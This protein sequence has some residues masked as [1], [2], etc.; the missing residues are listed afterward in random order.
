MSLGLRGRPMACFLAVVLTL[1]LPCLAQSFNASLS[2]VIT[3]STGALVPG[4]ELTLTNSATGQ[5]SKFVTDDEGRYSFQNL[6]PGTYDL[7][8]TLAGFKEFRQTGIELPINAKARLNITLQV[9]GVEQ[10]VQVQ[11][12]AP[13]LNFEN[14]TREEGVSP[15]TLEK[16]PLLVSGTV[17]SAAGFAVLMPGVSTGGGNNAFDARINGGVQSGDEAQVD[18][19]SMQQGT[20][21]QSG[22]ISIFQ[23]FPFSPD[24]VSEVK[25]LTSNYEPQYGGTAGATI[26]AETKSGT[27]DFHASGFWFHRNTV[28]N[29]R[30]FGAAERPKNLQHN[31]GA[32]VGGPV[33][34]PFVWSDKIKTYFYFNHEQFRVRGGAT[35]PI[36]SIP[37]LKNRAGD[38]SDWVD[39][40]GNLIP[41][42]DPDTTRPNPS[43]NAAQE[44]GPNNLPFLRDQFMGCNGNQ[45]NV[46]C[47]TRFQN[48]LALAWLKYLPEP[49]FSGALRNYQAPPVPDII[50]ANTKYYFYRIDT[51]I[52]ERDHLYFSSWSQYAPPNFNSTLPQ[53]LASEDLTDPQNSK[54]A[55][56]NWTH[57]FTPT[58]INHFSIGY[59][60]RNEGYG[61]LNQ[62]FVNDFPKIAGVAGYPAPPQINFSDGYETFG[63]DAGDNTGNVTTRPTMIGNSM[64][65]W[66]KSSHTFKFGG[67]YRDLGQNFHDGTNRAGTF[68]FDSSTTG[69]VG[70]PTS[71]NPIA[72]F[73][74]E[75]VASGSVA[76]RSVAA[77]YARQKAFA[78]YGG[79][80]WKINPKWTLNYGLRWDVFTPAVEKYDRLSFFDPT[81]LNPETG[82]PGALAFAPD[83]E[84]RFD[85]R[86]PE[87]TWYGGF[88]PRLGLAYAL[89]DKTAIRTGYGIFYHQ[90][91]CP[92]WGGCLS[93]EGY[94]STVS[95][96]S[97]QQGLTPAFI[98]SQGFP[99]NFEQPPFLEPDF[100]NGRDL[101]YRPFEANRRAY[102]QQWN[103]TV[104]RQITNDLMVSVGYVGTAGRRL[105]S[106]VA[107]INV[108][109]PSLLSMGEALFDQF[110]PGVTSLNGV[111]LPYNGWLEDLTCDPT[112]AQAMLPY[113][114]YCSRLQGINENAGFSKYH[115]FQM[116][117]DKRFSKG[118]FLLVAYTHQKLITTTGQTNDAVGVVADNGWGGVISPYQRQRAIAL[119]FDDVPH[120]L[121]T[122][123][124]YEAPWRVGGALGHLANNWAMT[125]IFRYSSGLPFYFRA[126][127]CRIPEQF[128]MGCLPNYDPSRLYAQDKDDFDPGRGPL[129]NQDAFE[130]TVFNFR[131]G[132]GTVS[133]NERGFAFYNH[134]VSF[135]KN[136]PIREH[137]NFQFRAEFFNIWNWHTFTASGAMGSR[138]F[139]TFVGSADFGNWNNSV[140]APRTVQ[141]GARLEF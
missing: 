122:S 83:F 112:V 1:F 95:F 53:Q 86:H 93:L 123:F 103:F 56:L 35:A 70:L 97:T 124:I 28:L 32:N 19:V 41:I 131:Q 34:L 130:A 69:L 115:S 36:L 30:Q 84:Q 64:A 44:A 59:L 33:K 100:R 10:V 48:S 29:A 47:P 133:T 14:A 13:Q 15:D 26:I 16:L 74:L 54:V 37:S 135:V 3:D 58:L 50:L 78:V 18:G 114:Q 31:F 127:E 128:R 61:S 46:I 45:P 55:R 51:N 5:H 91:Y 6:T 139:D 129:I 117:V 25:V 76:F 39:S 40:S 126:D 134:D 110:T 2:G 22:M 106:Y 137:V 4:V 105:P 24:M 8:A 92:G 12:S 42:Y 38:F 23:D 89:N 132:D 98:L 85:R 65:T 120:I 90:A 87:E 101:T 27:N 102:S 136:T 60:N 113:P 141:F 75:Q 121:S 104:E 125:T 108:L 96:D 82:K 43:F 94:N 52:G 81:L 68:S 11:G 111:S 49:T 109:N 67:E 79:D 80:T 66:V 9:G 57:T 71:G 73:L 116:K 138:A 21:S 17:R 7:S 118:T 62:E 63:N 72:S 20:M 88:A 99:Q 119:A 77:N 107:P 140:S